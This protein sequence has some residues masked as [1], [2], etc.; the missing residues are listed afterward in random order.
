MKG[1]ELKKPLKAKRIVKSR[2]KSPQNQAFFKTRSGK[3]LIVLLLFCILL[4]VVSRYPAFIEVY[5]SQGLY[6]AIAAVLRISFGWIPFSLGDL[7]Y[8]LLGIFILWRLIRFTR[9]LIQKRWTRTYGFKSL[10]TTLYVSAVLYALFYLFW[11]LNY[12]RLG[13][14]HQLGLTVTQD[15]STQQLQNLTQDLLKKTNHDRLQLGNPIEL[16]NPKTLFNG[17]EQA[18]Q[19]LKDQYPFLAYHHKS[20]KVPIYNALGGYLQYTGY[21][22]PFTGEAQVNTALP[23]ILLP[24]VACHEMAHQLGYATEDEANFVGFLAATSSTDPLFLY[25]THLELF[26]YA[27]SELWYRDSNMARRNFNQL[28]TLVKQDLTHLKT[29]FEAHENPIGKFT[30]K[31]YGLFLK[32]NQ[33]PQ[34]LDTYDQVTA[35]LLAYQK[36]GK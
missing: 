31:L 27:N 15:Y 22:N 8:T 24:Y 5:Y 21:Y 9:T 17:A 34:G 10:Y 36:R 19:H 35:W 3:C 25:S 26:R 11:G 1:K 2:G 12:S 32:A 14:A 7:L 28:D 23:G 30:T 6:P 16:P 13:I 4:S 20:I 33:Q 18:Y 29:F